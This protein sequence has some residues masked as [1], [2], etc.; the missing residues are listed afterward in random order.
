MYVV[1]RI[2]FVL[3]ELM[4]NFLLSISHNYMVSNRIGFLL[5]LV[6]RIGLLYYCG[7]PLAFYIIIMLL[8]YVSFSGFLNS[9]GN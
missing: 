1:F 5:L 7:I 8:I 4:L 3:R 2:F 6:N 9:V